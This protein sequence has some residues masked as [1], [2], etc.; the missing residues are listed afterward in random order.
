MPPEEFLR[1]ALIDERATIYTI[2]KMALEFLGGCRRERKTWQGPPAMYDVMRRA[3]EPD[4][5]DRYESYAAFAADW[6]A[7][8]RGQ[9]DPA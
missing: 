6:R 7:G 9:H 5:H 4:P 2:G 1:G 3:T 8:R